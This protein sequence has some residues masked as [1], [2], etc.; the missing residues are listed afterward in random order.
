VFTAA[1]G[2]ASYPFLPG[3]RFRPAAFWPRPSAPTRMGFRSKLVLEKLGFDP[4]QRYDA[5]LGRE[6]PDEL[7]Q[8]ASRLNR[9]G[10]VSL[11]TASQQSGQSLGKPLAAM[12]AK[13]SSLIANKTAMP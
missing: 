2:L 8:L 5:L 13:V 1:S 6:L 9:D 7:G 11:S 10:G 12:A 4:W 3:F